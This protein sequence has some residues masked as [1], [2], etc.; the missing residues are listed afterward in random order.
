M[1]GEELNK[2]KEELG[3]S[4]RYLGECANISQM[5]IS[6]IMN[7]KRTSVSVTTYVALMEELK[8]NYEDFPGFVHVNLYDENEFK[9]GSLFLELLCLYK[10]Q[11]N[12]SNIALGKLLGISDGEVYRI[13]N[14]QR[15]S[16]NINTIY[17]ICNVIG[18]EYN[19]FVV[20]PL[21]NP[22]VVK[23]TSY[24]LK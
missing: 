22:I 9:N 6:R 1:Y 21:I 10:Y 19:L 4:T 15:R 20:N 5:E 17:R 18:V 3:L 14:H 24:K 13:I 11:N 7:D 2:R 16:L 12:L 8:L 23:G